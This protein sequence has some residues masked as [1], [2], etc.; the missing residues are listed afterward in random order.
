MSNKNTHIPITKEL[1]SIIDQEKHLGQ[2]YTGY[3]MELM[4]EVKN[5]K[6]ELK[7]NIP[8]RNRKGRYV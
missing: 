4:Q 8:L 7:V 5:L 6:N 1:K 3:I 2:S